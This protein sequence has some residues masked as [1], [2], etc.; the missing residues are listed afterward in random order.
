MT[1]AETTDPKGCLLKLTN[2]ETIYSD[3]VWLA[4]GTCPDL[5]TMGFLHPILENVSFVDEYPVLD[6]SLRLK[7][8]PIYLM[9]RSTTYALGPAAG[10]LWGATR[11]AH[12]ITTDIT[13][14]EFISNGT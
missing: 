3:Q 1:S 8:Y 11:A 12:R 7:P 5:Q 4:T 6:R 10:N 2:D 14:V 13:G 9:G